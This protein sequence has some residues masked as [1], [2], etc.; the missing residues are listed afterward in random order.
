MLSYIARRL[1]RSAFTLLCVISLVFLLLRQMPIEGYFNNYEKMTPTQVRV[2]LERMGL[3][4][5]VGRQLWNFA[6]SLAKGDLGLSNRYRVGYPIGKLIS[7]KMPLSLSIGGS[8][9]LLSLAA[10][11]PFGAW[12][13]QSASSPRKRKSVDKAGSALVA[14][15]EAIPPSVYYLFIQIYGTELLNKL[16][17]VP[18]LFSASNPRTWILPVFSLSL[19]NMAWYALWMRR[20][21]IDESTRDYAALARAKGVPAGEISGNH[22][23]RNAIVPLAQYIPTSFVATLMGS[24]YVESRYS[25]PGMGGL[26]VDAIKRQDNSLVQALVVLYTA[27]SIAAVLLGDL[28]MAALDPRI[29]LA[30][31]EAS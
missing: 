30:G 26:L 4:Q 28:L 31:R 19:G 12:M 11:L 8:A 14:L 5:P 29:R 3:N 10:G 6:A 2:G 27:L 13:A 17:Y 25:I 24:L 22:V 7:Q 1:A 15:I 16:F 23:F 18:F 9:M 21:M 20:Y